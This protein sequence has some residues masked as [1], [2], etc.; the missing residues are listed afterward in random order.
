MTQFNV[1]ATPETVTATINTLSEHGFLPELLDNGVAAFNRIKELIPAGAS[2]MNGS[3]RTLTEIGYIDYL[4]AGEHGWNNVHESILKETDPV[5][6]AALREQSVISDYYLGSVHALTAT[7]QL[8]I[9]SGSGSQLP[10]IVYTSKNLIFVVSTQKIVAD[11]NTAH[12][13]LTDYVYPL[14]DQ[15]MK[16]A[17]MGGSVITYV[18]TVNSEPS[19]KNRKIHILLVNEK[20]GF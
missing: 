17:N 14:E 11:L 5:K 6:Q 3:S 9:A 7:G 10:H 13:R 19:W 16:D 18:L 12:E 15:R 1:L 8:L 2:V 4:K 20:L